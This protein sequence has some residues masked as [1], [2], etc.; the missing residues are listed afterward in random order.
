MRNLSPF[1]MQLAHIWWYAEHPDGSRVHERRGDAD[2]YSEAIPRVELVL[3][4]EVRWSE[5]SP[6]DR[7][8]W[9]VRARDPELAADQRYAN[10]YDTHELPNRWGSAWS[11]FRMFGNLNIGDSRL[12]NLQVPGQ[13]CVPFTVKNLYAV[14]SR[15]LVGREA[16]VLTLM[17][18]H[19]H[20]EWCGPLDEA[21]RGVPVSVHLPARQNITVDSDVR[22]WSAEPISIRV[23]LEGLE[24]QRLP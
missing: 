18:C 16:L 12:T 19:N 13:F 23:H 24:H 8:I 3:R 4:G 9:S 1:L 10:Y 14:P 15:D 17:T 2:L 6:G 11:S 7:A 20:V 21:R 22:H 5:S